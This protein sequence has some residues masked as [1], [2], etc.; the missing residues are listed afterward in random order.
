MFMHAPNKYKQMCMYTYTHMH[1]HTYIGG[2]SAPVS[3]GMLECADGDAWWAFGAAY[4]HVYMYIYIHT[5]IHV[6][7]HIHTCTHT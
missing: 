4:V 2:G 1:V 7:T 3:R 5:H 6:C